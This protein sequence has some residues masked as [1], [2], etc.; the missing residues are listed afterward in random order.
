MASYSRRIL[1]CFWKTTK[2]LT[3]EDSARRVPCR[4]HQE[5]LPT[6]NYLLPETVEEH[7]KSELSKHPELPPSI[8]SENVPADFRFVYPEFLPDPQYDR[9]DSIRERLEREDM[10]RRR[11][12]IDIPEFYVGSIMAVTVSDQYSPNKENR[13]VGICIDRGGVGLRAFFILRNVVDGQGIE[14]MYEMYNPTLQSIQVLK[15]E[16]RVDDKLYYLRDAPQEYSTFPFD[17]DPIPVPKGSTVPVNK[18]KVQLN[19]RPWLERW[20]RQDLQGVE[21]LKL[22]QRFYDKA[23]KVAKPWEKYDLMKWYRENT[24][25][26]ERDSIMQEV[27]QRKRLTD[28]EKSKRKT[29]LAERKR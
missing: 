21:D 5:L 13:F 29:K 24:N 18:M 14:I 19:P 11:A 6:R 3:F 10:Y 26:E 7:R 16:K 22:E 28:I 2:L 20:E 25:E 27:H 1:P 9:R 8:T 17:M 4:Y 23:A 12:V 15:L